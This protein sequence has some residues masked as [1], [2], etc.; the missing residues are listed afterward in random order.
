VLRDLLAT[1]EITRAATV[2]PRQRVALPSSGVSVIPPPRFSLLTQ[3]VLPVAQSH[4]TFTRVGHSVSELPWLFEVAR[5]SLNGGDLEACCRAFYASWGRQGVRQESLEV[6]GAPSLGGQRTLRARLEG[7]LADG[8]HIRSRARW[9]ERGSDAIML[10]MS[11]EWTSP[12][13]S[14][15]MLDEAAAS[16]EW[17]STDN[18]RPWWRFW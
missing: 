1:L 13:E 10:S 4:A 6:T 7:L 16:L 14:V 17:L 9:V 15:P 5:V 18:A 3:G 12:E 2:P 8:S 11:S